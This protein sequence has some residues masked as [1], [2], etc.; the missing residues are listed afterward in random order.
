MIY[1]RTGHM[2]AM[3]TYLLNN[4]QLIL[5]IAIQAQARVNWAGGNQWRNKKN[6]KYSGIVLL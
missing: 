1:I 2:Y 3:L 4:Q 6:H 5:S